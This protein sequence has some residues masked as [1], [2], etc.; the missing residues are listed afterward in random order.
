M[1]DKPDWEELGLAKEGVSAGKEGERVMLGIIKG[2]WGSAI[3]C[4][5]PTGLGIITGLVLWG[6]SRG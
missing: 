4:A 5:I 3:L 2:Y 6:L 1:W